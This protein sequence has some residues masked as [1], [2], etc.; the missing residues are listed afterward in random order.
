MRSSSRDD[1]RTDSLDQPPISAGGDQFQARIDVLAEQRAQLLALRV[2]QHARA[3]NR[4]SDRVRFFHHDLLAC[5]ET[6]RGHRECE[7]DEQPGQR[8]DGSLPRDGVRP[9]RFVAD[10]APPPAELVPKLR[11]GRQDEEEGQCNERV[12]HSPQADADST[13]RM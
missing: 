10:C 6:R 4:R 9:R 8:E 7:S 3:Q 1:A 5:V 12:D 13:G 2:V 11:S